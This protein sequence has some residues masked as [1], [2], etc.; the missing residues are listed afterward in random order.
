MER[1]EEAAEAKSDGERQYCGEREARARQDG[2]DR[3]TNIL[4]E[5]FGSP[6]AEENLYLDVSDCLL[7]SGEGR[8]SK[9]S[10]LRY[11]GT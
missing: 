5:A 2:P 6:H 9:R 4:H 7:P 3:K 8:T 11:G 10:A 1:V